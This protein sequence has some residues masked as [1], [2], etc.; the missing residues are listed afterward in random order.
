MFV[1]NVSNLLFS[2]VP[3]LQTDKD[4]QWQC[5]YC[6]TTVWIISTLPIFDPSLP[7]LRPRSR[8]I[9]WVPLG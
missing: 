2:Q 7:S 3:V 6:T 9:L 1:F 4:K 5:W 8:P